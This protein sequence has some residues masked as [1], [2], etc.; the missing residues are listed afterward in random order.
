MEM[1]NWGVMKKIFNDIIFFIRKLLFR[2]D[3]PIV[4]I[5]KPIVNVKYIHTS[6]EIELMGLINEYRMTIGLSELKESN[7]ISYL[8]SEHNK[9]MISDNLI[10][11]NGFIGRSDLIITNLQAKVIGENIGYN[12]NTA[13]DVLKSWLRNPI[14]K[15]NIED[16]FTH[17]GLSISKDTKGKNYFTNIFYK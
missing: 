17:F 3:K 7:Y 15:K 4:V 8:A 16:S 9:E 14:Y 1:E 5:V 6:I 12:F 11:H 2:Y 13:L 10:S